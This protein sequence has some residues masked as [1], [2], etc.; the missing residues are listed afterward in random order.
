MSPQSIRDAQPMK[1]GSSLAASSVF[2]RMDDT[3][4]DVPNTASHTPATASSHR[5]SRRMGADTSTTS[6]QSSELFSSSPTDHSLDEYAFV[7]PELVRSA[8]SS[9]S[10][11]SIFVDHLQSKYNDISLKRRRTRALGA[12]PSSTSGGSKCLSLYFCSFSHPTSFRFQG[13]R[14]TI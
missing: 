11:A 4:S 9:D 7:A 8:T 13:A 3:D 2:T 10:D 14:Y 12:M 1:S 5:S 6:V